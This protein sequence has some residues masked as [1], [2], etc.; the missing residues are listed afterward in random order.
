MRR[1]LAARLGQAA[2]A[3]DERRW[4][5]LERQAATAGGTVV[6]CSEL[7]R[8]R[9]GGTNVWVVPNGYERAQ[10]PA[11]T[12]RDPTPAAA[13]V[14]IMV[15]L[16]TY[17]PNRDAADFFAS[18]ILPH[19]RRSH[20]DA[21]FHMVGR[22]DSDAAVHP[23]RNLPGVQVLG[24]VADVGAELAAA[25]IAVVPIRFGGGTRIKILEA[26]AHRIPVVSTTVGCEGLDVVD[27]EHL[28]VADD[29]ASFASACIRLSEDA[30]LRARLVAAAAELWTSRYR[31]TVLSP[32]HY[33]RRAGCGG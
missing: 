13:P 19:I 1:Q 30:D 15:G 32:G 11:P 14:L 23:W 3:V 31:W 12:E 18:T 33:Q 26:F 28:L 25:D 8:K 4:R 29:P 20:P 7:D 2:D 21:R 22:Y 9:L 27:G 16:L 24:E 17:E 6:V 5:R 10:V